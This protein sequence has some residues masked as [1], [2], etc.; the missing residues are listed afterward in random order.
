ML[1]IT[2]L[3]SV[4]ARWCLLTCVCKGAG[5][6]RNV[7]TWTPEKQFP[8]FRLTETTLAMPWL[9]PPG[10]TIITVDIGCEVGDEMWK[11]ADEQLGEFCLDNLTPLI[12]D[13]RQRSLGC[14]VLRT[15][16]AYPIF[17]REYEADRRR[18]AL[19]TGVVRQTRC[20]L[21]TSTPKCQ[22]PTPNSRQVRLELGVGCWKFRRWPARR[23][24]SHR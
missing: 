6:C 5:C 2:S 17:L 7:V 22:L 19:S 11:M 20:M 13:V 4:T 24:G 12:P 1:S 9:A 14:H 10:K 8:F 21:F 15:P 23:R 16:I 18:F 3:D